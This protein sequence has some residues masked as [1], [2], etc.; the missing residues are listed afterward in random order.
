VFECDKVPGLLGVD[1]VLAARNIVYSL[2]N[3]C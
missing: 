2:N 3:L 1:A